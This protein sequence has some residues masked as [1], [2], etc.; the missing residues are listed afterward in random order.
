MGLFVAVVELL[1]DV[2][3]HRFEYFGVIPQQLGYSTESRFGLHLGN[4][5]PKSSSAH[6]K[7][8]FEG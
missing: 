1:L 8:C 4:L 6:Y 5:Q 2:V 7:I 3:L